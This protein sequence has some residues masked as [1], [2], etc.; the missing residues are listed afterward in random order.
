MKKILFLTDTNDSFYSYIHLRTSYG[1]LL[2]RS[3]KESYNLSRNDYK[4]ILLRWT[5]SK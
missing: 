4:S 2:A 1:Y 3:S 5:F